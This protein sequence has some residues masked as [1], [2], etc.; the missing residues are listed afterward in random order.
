MPT[1]TA[2]RRR[3]IVY[4]SGPYRSDRGEDGVW[5]NIMAAR[6]AAKR[7][8]AVGFAPICPHLNTMLMG[9]AIVPGNADVEVDVFLE[10]DAEFVRVAD[11]M[12]QLPGWRKSAGSLYEFRVA[13]LHGKPVFEDGQLA[14]TWLTAWRRQHVGLDR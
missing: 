9:G 14:E 1:V 11:A 8:L 2:A 12:Y 4:I 6:Q 10:A 13:E 7:L 3:P 5:G